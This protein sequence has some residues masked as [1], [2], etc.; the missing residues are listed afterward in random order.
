MYRI[1]LFSKMT[2]VTIKALRFYEAEGLLVPDY[3][4]PDSGYRYYSSPQLS[5]VYRIVSLRQC[6]FSVVQIRQILDGRNIEELFYDQRNKLEEQ[7]LET[8]R[9]LSSVNH[10]LES[11]TEAENEKYDVILKE[12]PSVIVYS[13][14]MVV[15]SYDDYFTVIPKIG[16]EVC[17]VNPGLCCVDD[18]PYCFI[19]YHD[20]EYREQRID[21]EFCEAVSERGQETER[22]KFK[23]IQSVKQAA[24]ALHKGSYSSLPYAYGAVFKWIEDNNLVIVGNPRE[25]YIDGIW[26]K[27]KND[28]EW[29][30]ELQVPVT[31][32]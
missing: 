22:I 10:Y 16:E 15:D 14:R 20:G 32:V 28:S 26:N 25:S 11:V 19:M 29:L 21:I 9:Q 31:T 23:E 3:I 6:G 7:A 17:R 8:A 12:L 27:N 13:C 1:G 30:T 4:D 24:C 18:P 2:K 5:H